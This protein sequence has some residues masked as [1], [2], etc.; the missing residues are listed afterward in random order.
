MEKQF[1]YS[2]PENHVE[3]RT[4]LSPRLR[5]SM[6][7]LPR[8][9]WAMNPAFSGEPEFWTQIHEGLLSAS[10]TL[11]A[12]ARQALEEPEASRLAQMAPQIKALGKRLIHHA[13]GHHHIEDDYFFPVFLKTFP[14]LQHPLELLDGDHKVLAEVLDGLEK[15]VDGFAVLPQGSERQRRDAWLA[16]ADALLPAAQRLDALFIRHIGDE[17]EICIPAM[18]QG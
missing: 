12:W 9:R 13:H 2:S 14:Q 5:S 10:A 1:I 16:G 18:L 3:Q 7:E 4:C 15:A 8:Q 17:E 6:F 11:A